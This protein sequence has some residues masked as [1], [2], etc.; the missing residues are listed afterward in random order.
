MNSLVFVLNAT[1]LRELFDVCHKNYFDDGKR[2]S[3][4]CYV[5]KL[6]K[7]HLQVEKNHQHFMEINF[8]TVLEI[9]KYFCPTMFEKERYKILKERNLILFLFLFCPT[10]F[11]AAGQARI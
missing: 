5:K 11:H 8:Q 2:C 9:K 6:K 10:S 4:R 1:V 7:I 3:L